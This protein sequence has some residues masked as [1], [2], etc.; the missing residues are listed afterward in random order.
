MSSLL[1]R[2]IRR[3]V[4]NAVGNAVG[5]AVQQA[6]EPKAT[7]FAN[8]VAGQIDAATQHAAQQGE[9]TV[10]LLCLQTR[11]LLAPPPAGLLY[12]PH[13]LRRYSRRAV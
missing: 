2:A 3:G 8:K 11:L 5:K 12:L 7:E 4:S 10:R 9:K 6:V 1:E 13:C